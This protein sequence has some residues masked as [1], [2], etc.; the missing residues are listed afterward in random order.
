MNENLSSNLDVGVMIP[1]N[2]SRFEWP[3]VRFSNYPDPVD[4][5]LKVEY[6]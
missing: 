3:G 2:E 5:T 4:M 1:Y 6:A